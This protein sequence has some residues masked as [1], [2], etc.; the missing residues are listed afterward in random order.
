[1][2]LADRY[3]PPKAVVQDVDDELAMWR[4][5]KV[6]VLRKG[7]PFPD[8]CIKCNAPSV[9]PRRRFKL[10]WHTPWIYPLVLGMLLLYAV[11]AAVVRQRATVEIGLCARHQQR[12]LWGRVFTWGGFLLELLLLARASRGGDDGAD[13][14]KLALC[15]FPV[16]ALGSTW[17]RRLVRPARIDKRHVRLHGCGAAFLASLPDRSPR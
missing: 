3:A 8:R 9:A 12:V 17:L 11:V 16:W 1:M 10:L 5:G 7:S 6:L 4:E 13:L 2:S 15:W 14:L